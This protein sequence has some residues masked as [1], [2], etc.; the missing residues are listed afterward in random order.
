[1]IRVG[2]KSSFGEPALPLAV[3]KEVSTKRG[4]RTGL[5]KADSV[6]IS[7]LTQTKWILSVQANLLFHCS[8]LYCGR[9]P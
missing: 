1:M 2:G 6:I 9:F 5:A 8:C 3:N 4:G 7:V